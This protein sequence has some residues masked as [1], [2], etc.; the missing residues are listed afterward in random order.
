MYYLGIDLAGSERRPTGLCAINDDLVAETAIA[1]LDGEIIAFVSKFKPAV[2]AIDAPLFLPKGRRSLEERSDVHLRK[3]DREMLKLGIKFFP[4]TLGPMRALTKRGMKLKEALERMG[5]VVLE[6]FPGGAQDIL[7]IPRSKDVSGLKSGLEK[8]G[9][10]LTKP[11]YTP[12]EL[13]AVTCALVS[14][15]YFKGHYTALGDPEEGYLIL[16]KIDK[17]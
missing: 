15:L 9:V 6:T 1:Y 17:Y 14:A 13:D 7:K 4:I 3:C 16:P 12:H 8:L 11:H 5:Y 2:I 10:K